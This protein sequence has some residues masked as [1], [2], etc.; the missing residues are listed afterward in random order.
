MVKVKEGH[1]W[2]AAGTQKTGLLRGSSFIT[3]EPT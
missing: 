3:L 2:E 1:R